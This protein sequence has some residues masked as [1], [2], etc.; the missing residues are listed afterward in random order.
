MAK[1]NVKFNLTEVQRLTLEGFQHTTVDMW[2]KFCRYVVDIENDYFDKD[3]LVDDMVDKI[4]IEYDGDGMEDE[5]EDDLLDEDDR[6]LI[7][8][9]LQLSQQNET[10]MTESTT[11]TNSQH[12][13]TD[14][15]PSFVENMDPNFLDCVLP[16]HALQTI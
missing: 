9:A 1:H 14:M 5:D 6:H 13:L 16:L 4:I 2:R 7:D 3:R 8:M 10:N 12:N 11:T 15:D